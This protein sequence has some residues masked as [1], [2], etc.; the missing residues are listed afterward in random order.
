MT[1]SASSLRRRHATDTSGLPSNNA[2][3]ACN[4]AHYPWQ[5]PPR[6]G[7]SAPRDVGRPRRLAMFEL[8]S[9]DG[10]CFEIAVQALLWSFPDSHLGRTGLRALAGPRP[11]APIEVP[12]KCG[13]V[14][15]IQNYA[16][17]SDEGT[18]PPAP[19]RDVLPD[20]VKLSDGWLGSERAADVLNFIQR[21]LTPH[22]ASDLLLASLAHAPVSLWDTV[23]A[24]CCR[25]LIVHWDAAMFTGAIARVDKNAAARER[26]LYAIENTL[27]DAVSKPW[28]IRP[29]LTTL[30]PALHYFCQCADREQLLSESFEEVFERLYAEGFAYQPYEI[31][32]Q[33]FGSAADD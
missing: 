25:H 21:G 5:S 16:R 8:Q 19:S 1:L 7:R 23:E 20:V 4:P 26:L 15:W 17:A 31:I 11:M 29:Y 30:S 22:L 6:A 13:A 28:D 14:A 24:E 32:Q 3:S 18:L 9:Q 12:A 33:R 2:S 27:A 10:A